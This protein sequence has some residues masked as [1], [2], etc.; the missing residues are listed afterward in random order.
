[1]AEI[2]NDGFVLYGGVVV[3]VMVS[4]GVVLGFGFDRAMSLLGLDL[5]KLHHDE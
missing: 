4:M 2:Y 3:L 1:V 5:G